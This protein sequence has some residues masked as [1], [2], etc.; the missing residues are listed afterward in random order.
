MQENKT[1]IA[2]ISCLALSLAVNASGDG[3]GTPADAAAAEIEKLGGLDPDSST[4]TDYSVYTVPRT[5]VVD[6]TGTVR[7]IT[8]PTDLTPQALNVLLVDKD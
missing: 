7:A 8:R 6:K 1:I 4:D 2:T 3:N 5:I